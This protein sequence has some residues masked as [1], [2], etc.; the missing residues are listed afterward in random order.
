MTHHENG[1]DA[2]GRRCSDIHPGCCML[3]QLQFMGQDQREVISNQDQ[4]KVMLSML[5]GARR[6]ARN[7]R[8]VKL[9]NPSMKEW[10]KTD[11]PPQ[12]TAQ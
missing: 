7:C 5:Y 4:G 3:N 8:L 10:H 9:N 6:N 2:M 11:V 1:G 12:V